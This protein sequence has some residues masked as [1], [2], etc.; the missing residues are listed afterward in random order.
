M[1]LNQINAPVTGDE[2]ERWSEIRMKCTCSYCDHCKYAYLSSLDTKT[3]AYLLDVLCAE[4]IV[5]SMDG[6]SVGWVHAEYAK[7][8]SEINNKPRAREERQIPLWKKLIG[9]I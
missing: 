2:L 1:F 4:P 5:V 6:E 3:S 9:V 7:R 8:I